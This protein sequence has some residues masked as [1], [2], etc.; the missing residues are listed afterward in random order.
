MAF[1]SFFGYCLFVLFGGVGLTALPMDLIKE[2]TNRPKK[3]TSAEGAQ[4]K[5]S[6]RRKAADLIEEGNKIKEDN[7]DAVV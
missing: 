2:F 7:K 6:L 5:S 3:L 4:K 1:M